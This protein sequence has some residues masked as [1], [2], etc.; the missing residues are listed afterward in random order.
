[1][2]L[3][4]P[5]NQMTTTQRNSTIPRWRSLSAAA[6]Q[7]WHFACCR[8]CRRRCG[9]A[10]CSLSPCATCAASRSAPCRR[11]SDDWEGRVL[12]SAR[13]IAGSGRAVAARAIAGG[14]VGRQPRSSGFARWLH[15]LGRPRSST[16]RSRPSR[17]ETARSRSRG[18]VN[19]TVASPP[20]P[21]PAGD[22]RPRFGRAAA[23]SSSPRRLPSTALI[24]TQE[25]P[26]EVR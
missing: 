6:S 5:T 15:A 16:P 26:H 2:P 21:T 23:S 20:V 14:A 12:R 3:L 11:R 10:A 1:M 18:C 17:R 19:S 22:R 13:G 8:R 7:R 4:A 24:S 25:R 9:R